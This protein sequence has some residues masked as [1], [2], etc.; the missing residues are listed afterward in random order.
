M[1]S[2]KRVAIITGGA[3]GIGYATAV[4]LAAHGVIPVIADIN[5]AAGEKSAQ[6]IRDSG[7]D[8]FALKVD[9]GNTDEIAQMID[10]VVARYGRLDILVNNAGILTNTQYDSVTGEEWD[11]MLNINLKGVFFA[12]REAIR[13]MKAQ[14][15]G[16]I[17]SIS[18]MAGRSG[19]I[20]AGSAYVAAKAAIIGLT[21]HLAKKV[22]ADGI[23]VNAVAPG[24]IE[25][26]MLKDFTQADLEA[27][28]KTIPMG[29]L[30]KPE[31]IA[32]TIAFIASDAAAFM[33]GVILDVNGGNYMA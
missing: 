21:R 32:E 16:R 27:I 3:R 33:T 31:E 22:A 30:G 23:T 25:S 5:I 18:S 11:R 1:K 6:N 15:W 29:R 17:I 4:S 14:G 20:S 19:G 28:Y 8:A 26:D 2:E 10:T 7:M 13:P 12:S 9:L 24:T